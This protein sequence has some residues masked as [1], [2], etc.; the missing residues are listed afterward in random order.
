MAKIIIAL[1]ILLLPSYTF[2][3]TT[4]LPLTSQETIN[5][6]SVPLVVTCN[7]SIVVKKI[8]QRTANQTAGTVL[9]FDLGSYSAY[10]TT[11][12]NAEMILYD[13]GD[14]AVCLNGTTTADMVVVSG[15]SNYT[16]YR[17]SDANSSSY[18]GDTIRDGIIT[19]DRGTSF[20]L[21]A[22]IVEYE[23]LHIEVV[24]SGGGGGGS[25]I[26]VGDTISGMVSEWECTTSGDTTNCEAIA[27]S[28]IGMY[29]GPNFQEWLFVGGVIIFL[30]S[31]M[32]W[33]RISWTNKA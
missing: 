3:L 18:Q 25:N 19:F 24:N 15:D 8:W 2:A 14:G 27:T 4:A 32:F 13:F 9:R 33:G 22:F 30:L 21:Q 16:H 10:A 1:F 12:N 11:T 31:F 17:W 20:F 23:Y 29:N 6:T 28:S 5:A 26:Y 7:D